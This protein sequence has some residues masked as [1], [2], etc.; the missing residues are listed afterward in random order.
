M[1]TFYA[2]KYFLANDSRA[3]LLELQ[4]R[5]YIEMEF[6]R[7]VPCAQ[8]YLTKNQGFCLRKRQEI[9]EIQPWVCGSSLTSV[10]MASYPAV[11]VPLCLLSLVAPCKLL[12]RLP[13]ATKHGRKHTTHPEDAKG[14]FKDVSD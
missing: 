1:G 12:P 5:S 13:L 9:K 3:A 10:S 11:N 14:T 4:L 2:Y 7:G 6:A 8:F